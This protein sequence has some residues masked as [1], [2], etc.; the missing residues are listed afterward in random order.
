MRREAQRR[1][2]PFGCL[3]DGQAL[4]LLPLSLAVF[5]LTLQISSRTAEVDTAAFAGLTDELLTGSGTGVAGG[6]ST[7]QRVPPEWR[8]GAG[9]E[10]ETNADTN[11]SNVL[12]KVA[13]ITT[14]ADTFDQIHVWTQYHSAL[15]VS[16]FILFV[17]GQAAQPDILAQ[18]QEL[19]NVLA[20]PRTP[21]LVYRQDHS[22]AWNE[23]WLA[24]FFHKPCNHHL[25]VRQSLNMEE[26]I[27]LARD[28]GIEWVIHMDT[29]ELM[30]PGGASHYSLQAVLA[31]IPQRVDNVIFPNY[32]ALPEQEDV[33]EPFTEVTLFKRNFAHVSPG[34]YYKAYTEVSRGNPN[35]F[36]TY[37]NGK[38][39][40][41]I[42]P[43]LRPNGAHRWFNY[44][45]RPV[46]IT[47]DSAA[48]L[49]YTYNKFSDLKSRRD[50]CDCAP[51]EADAQRCFILPFDRMAFLAA[52]LKTDDE[53][54]EWFRERLV[55][56]D[57]PAVKQLVKSGLFYRIYTPQVLIRG[58]IYMNDR[59][60]TEQKGSHH[61]RTMIKAALGTLRPVA[62]APAAQ[63]DATVMGGTKVGRIRNASVEAVA[64]VGDLT[65]RR[66]SHGSSSKWQ[67]KAIQPQDA[68]GRP[69]A[70][71]ELAD[72]LQLGSVE[73]RSAVPPSP[74]EVN[75]GGTLF[76]VASSKSHSDS[77]A[78]R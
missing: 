9:F 32:E 43:G 8:V 58:F 60:K 10:P 36:I 78:S 48:V 42:R 38:S 45:R 41:R 75:G 68:A 46:E 57:A 35:Y 44:D 40:A 39:A 66:G 65:V 22:R 28:A 11:S 31:A 18:L 24:A 6:S 12:P 21:D 72:A 64:T 76:G 13:F 7:Y 15:G 69:D 73:D 23:S 16:L 54:M 55:W 53:L 34:V 4:V 1:Y 77:L 3:C 49:H 50:R 20:V 56:S 70:R 19:P 67:D 17:D 25:F 37:G 5:A 14:T 47:H 2:G 74:V 63:V 59:S 52:S 71:F 62:A 26:G 27:N 30:Y 29:D 61:D 51:T 33:R